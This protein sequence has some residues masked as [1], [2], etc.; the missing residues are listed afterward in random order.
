M[1]RHVAR[2]HYPVP[3]LDSA[4]VF[5]VE[6]DYQ[7]SFRVL[8]I[9][10]VRANSKSTP[11]PLAASLEH[12]TINALGSTVWNRDLA[13]IIKAGFLCD[14]CGLDTVSTGWCVAFAMELHEKGILAPK[15]TDL[16]LRWGNPDTV[17]EAIDRIVHTG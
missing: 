7:I 17:L 13:S 4:I 3:S 1:L 15:D 16:D 12:E 9:S 5:S 14:D 8:V 6:E 11:T 10:A 2:A